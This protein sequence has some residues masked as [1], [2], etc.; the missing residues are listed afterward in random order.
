MGD[1]R[2]RDKPS[3][4]P[5][6]FACKGRE[7]QERG[8]ARQD[9]RRG[10]AW[11][12]RAYPPVPPLTGDRARNARGGVAPPPLVYAQRRHGDEGRV[13]G[14]ERARPPHP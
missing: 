1:I 2:T 5:L 12:R 9:T 6:Q 7:T 3:P 10:T 13:R 14:R 4:P 11:G 8:A